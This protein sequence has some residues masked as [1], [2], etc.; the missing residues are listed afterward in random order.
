M[1]GGEEL[2]VL[3]SFRSGIGN[4]AI[5]DDR[6]Y[7]IESDPKVGVGIEFFDSATRQVRQVAGL[8]KVGILGLGIAVSPDRRHILYTQ[9]DQVGADIMLVENFR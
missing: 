5:V 1:D 4:W 8:G 6:I 3:S 7:F 2:Q 9:A